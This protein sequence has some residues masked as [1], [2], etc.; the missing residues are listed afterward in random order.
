MT[1]SAPSLPRA[2]VSGRPRVGGAPPPI[3]AYE[4]D[5][6]EARGVIDTLRRA[7][8]P[9]ASW[10]SIA[11]LARTNA[12]LVLFER[13]LQAAG[14]PF[15]SGGG[16]SYLARPTVRES[17]DRLAASSGAAGFQ[18]WLEELEASAAGPSARAVDEQDDGYCIG[19]F[20]D[21]LHNLTPVDDDVAELARLALEYLRS[22][23]NPSPSAFVTWLEASLRAD[24]PRQTG[25][26]VDL[27][28]FHR[29]KGLEW[30]VVFVTGLEDGLVPIAHA[31]SVGAVAEERRLLYVAC[32]RAMDELCCSW[33]REVL[34]RSSIGPGP[35]AVPRSHR[36][37]PSRPC[38]AG[39]GDARAFARF[40]AGGAG[41]ARGARAN[42][43]RRVNGLD[44]GY[45]ATTSRMLPRGG[46]SE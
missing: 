25:D 46:S 41:F 26:A 37:H 34:R 12:Q 43:S 15:R 40:P 30:R 27:V 20:Q 31:R 42:T 8:S 28:T 11:V 1:R 7:R 14:I 45:R 38:K 19:P 32:T 6:D 24:P 10:S 3:V 22:D 13:E 9:G 35:V 39:C 18:A 29:A 2:L 33:A 5:A 4:S 16:R 36:G 23:S 17:L 44:A 21:D